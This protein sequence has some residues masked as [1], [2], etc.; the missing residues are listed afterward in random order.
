MKFVRKPHAMTDDQT[1]YAPESERGE[2]ERFG[3]A[4]DGRAFNDPIVDC[5][6]RDAAD[7]DCVSEDEAED[8]FIRRQTDEG[9][10]GL[11]V[12]G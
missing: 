1:E 3:S 8:A 7:C 9:D 11:D 10:G 12:S 5:C 2:G 4:P 6:G